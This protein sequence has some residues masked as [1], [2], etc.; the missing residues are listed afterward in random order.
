[1]EH[2]LAAG[3]ARDPLGTKRSVESPLEGATVRRSMKR[4]VLHCYSPRSSNGKGVGSISIRQKLVVA[5]AAM[6]IAVAIFIGLE[7]VLKRPLPSTP[8]LDG[9]Q[10]ML[11][12][13]GQ[14][15]RC[16]D[17]RPV[18]LPTD[19]SILKSAP[20]EVISGAPPFESLTELQ[21][22]IMENETAAEYR[23]DPEYLCERFEIDLS[24]LVPGNGP[25]SSLARIIQ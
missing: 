19:T 1:M 5:V 2:R 8:T 25:A 22:W 9:F 16:E 13:D 17:R 6:A 11:G 10:L 4:A 21:Q 7:R 18:P 15:E 20:I 24:D 12:A 14:V 3:L 23:P